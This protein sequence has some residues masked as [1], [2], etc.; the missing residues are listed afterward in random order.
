M[1]RGGYR[2]G[3]GRKKGFPA[4]AAEEFRRRLCERIDKKAELYLDAWESLALGHKVVTRDFDG[5]LVETYEIPP[6]NTALRD[7]TNRAFGRPELPIEHSGEIGEYGL[8]EKERQDLIR[9]MGYEE[10]KDGS[11]DTPNSK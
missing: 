1:S 6:D 5:K 3:A 11:L 7:I 10:E 2:K 9:F 4:F 8:T